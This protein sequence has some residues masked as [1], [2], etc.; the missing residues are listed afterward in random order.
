MKPQQRVALIAALFVS[1]SNFAL[2]ATATTSF[3]VN[4]TV[5]SN[6]LVSSTSLNFGTYDPLSTSDATAT[7]T[8]NVK[9][10]KGTA[11]TIALNAGTRNGATDSTRQMTYTGPLTLASSEPMSYGLYSDSLY[12]NNW[13][14]GAAA[15][16]ASTGVGLNTGIDHTVYGKI[17]KNQYNVNAGGYQ[18][19]IVATISY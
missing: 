8:I 1:T 2:A 9:C 4:A 17:P 7:S 11:Y 13:G 14:T 18:D 5:A 6:C 12:A 16:V 3:T 15:T 19:T 10:S